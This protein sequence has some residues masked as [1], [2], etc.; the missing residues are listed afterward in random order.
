MRERSLSLGLSLS[1]SLSLSPSL[2]T[3]RSLK[4]AG[5][6]LSSVVVVDADLASLWRS[7]VQHQLR[8]VSASRLYRLSLF[9]FADYRGRASLVSVL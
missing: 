3:T 5:T 8:I 2:K 7:E 9:R 4:I 6:S 1:V